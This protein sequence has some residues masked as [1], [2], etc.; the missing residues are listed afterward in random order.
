M[1]RI[2]PRALAASFV[3]DRGHDLIEDGAWCAACGD[4]FEVG[5]QVLWVPFDGVDPRRGVTPIDLACY[6]GEPL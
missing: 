6:Q 1:K 2:T 5:D 3:L 4:E